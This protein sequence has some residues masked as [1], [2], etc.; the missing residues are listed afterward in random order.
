[1]ILE[2]RLGS[3]CAVAWGGEMQQVISRMRV[4]VRSRGLILD[5]E[6]LTAEIMGTTSSTSVKAG[7]GYAVRREWFR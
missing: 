1:V 2:E 3:D 4:R 7:E 5:K 6:R